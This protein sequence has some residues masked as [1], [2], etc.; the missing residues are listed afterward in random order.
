MCV[1]DMAQPEGGVDKMSSGRGRMQGQ[2]QQQQEAAAATDDNNDDTCR[3]RLCQRSK[4][5]QGSR[6]RE[7]ESERAEAA[8]RG[9]H[10]AGHG[11]S[12]SCNCCNCNWHANYCRA[13]SSKLADDNIAA[14]R[15]VE[16]KGRG[17]QQ[18]ER[19]SERAGAGSGHATVAY[20]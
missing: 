13:C 15:Q 4:W 8:A 1:N 10:I 2:R 5:Q 14:A 11:N 20:A 17:M 9:G 7:R 18:R 3:R 12:Q 19:G 16:F 6:E